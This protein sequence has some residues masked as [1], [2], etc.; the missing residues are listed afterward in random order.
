MNF[1]KKYKNILIVLLVCV[2]FLYAA[3]LFILPNAINLNNYKSDIQKIV[4]ENAK[5]HFDFQELKIVT[6]PSLKA[7]IRIK[8]AEISYPESSKF[9]SLDTAEVKISLLPLLFKTLQISDISV[10]KANV[11]LV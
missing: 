7:G 1:L 8:G 3:F 5:L 11:F 9:A 10:N 2:A 4:E 6:T